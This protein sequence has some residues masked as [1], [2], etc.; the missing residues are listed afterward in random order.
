MYVGI[1]PVYHI[2]VQHMQGGQKEVWREMRVVHVVNQHMW[3]LGVKPCPLQEQLVL[4][5]D[6][7]SPP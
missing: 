3:V 4:S 5:T 6:K 2:P 7:P 1:L